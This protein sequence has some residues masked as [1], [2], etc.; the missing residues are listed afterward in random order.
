MG[1]GKEHD[2]NIL[3]ENMF[4]KKEGREGGREG[5][6]RKENINREIG[7]GTCCQP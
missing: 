1:N 4:K 3:Y 6:R 7:K 2:Q 5:E